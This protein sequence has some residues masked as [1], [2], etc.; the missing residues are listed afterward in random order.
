RRSL[1]CFQD[2]TADVKR[3][4]SRYCYKG[5]FGG[6]VTP[7]FDQLCSA[8]RDG[9]G[10]GV[11]PDWFPFLCVDSSSDNSPFLGLFYHG[12]TR[13]WFSPG[14]SFGRSDPAAAPRPTSYSQDV[15][16]LTHQG[17][18]L[19]VPQVQAAGSCP[20]RSRTESRATGVTGVGIKEEVVCLMGA[21]D[22]WW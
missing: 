16:I 10:G 2:C 18:K 12:H 1:V 11:S 21:S 6:N 13:S 22:K 19:L 17:E 7:A 8:R 14:F 4:F 20:W 9:E 5:A 3:L 15:P